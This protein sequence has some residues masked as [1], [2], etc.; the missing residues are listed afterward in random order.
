M[1]KKIISLRAIWIYLTTVCIISSAYIA[2]LFYLNKFVDSTKPPL[3]GS[4]QYLTDSLKK[5]EHGDSY[6]FLILG[7]SRGNY[8]V[9]EDLIKPVAKEID[10][11]III[12]DASDNTHSSHKYLRQTMRKLDLKVPFFYVPGNNDFGTEKRQK[13]LNIFNVDDFKKEYGP[14]NFSFSYHNDLFIAVCS[15]GNKK[16]TKESLRFLQN[17]EKKR[18]HYRHCFVFMHIPPPLPVSDNSQF[19]ADSQFVKLFEKLKV[20]YVFASHYHGYQ[21]TLFNG[22]DYIITGGAGAE[23]DIK[24]VRQFYHSIEFNI[25]PD[26]ISRRFIYSPEDVDFPDWLEVRSRLHVIP[27]LINHLFFMYAILFSLAALWALLT[28]YLFRTRNA[29]Q[30]K[31]EH[32]Q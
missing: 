15:V 28:F 12:G 17:F 7:D 5:N 26:S 30:K 16:Y 22:V 9:E 27:F 21:E 8:P 11:A 6:K 29:T 3:F 4:G 31:Y 2:Y 32:I 23:L 20:D 13:Y 18:S 14:L 24:T 1:L 10:F 19:Y 25:A